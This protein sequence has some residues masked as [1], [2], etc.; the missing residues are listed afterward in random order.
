MGKSL[1][2][3]VIV[4]AI[5]LSGCGRAP[6][7]TPTEHALKN[8]TLLTWQLNDP[9]S[10]APTFSLNEKN[11]TTGV[12]TTG[13]TYPG[14][15]RFEIS[16]DHKKV[17]VTVLGTDFS[18]TIFMYDVAS[19]KMTQIPHNQT[20]SYS[21]GGAVFDA[22]SESFIIQEDE[23]IWN[24]SHAPHALFKKY[25]KAGRLL[26][27]KKIQLEKDMSL[28]AFHMTDDNNLSA[29][30]SQQLGKGEPFYS[31]VAN[32]D[33]EKGTLTRVE[34]TTSAQGYTNYSWLSP[35]GKY[36]VTDTELMSVAC[37]NYERAS[38]LSVTNIETSEEVAPLGLVDPVEPIELLAWSPDETHV[39]L[40][41]S[42]T[43]YCE[44]AETPTFAIIDLQDEKVPAQIIDA[45]GVRELLL[46]NWQAADFSG[47]LEDYIFNT[48]NII[49]IV[50]L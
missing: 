11:L 16:P 9:G 8:P 34:N 21:P 31:Y 15:P 19:R 32:I 5:V 23:E 29:V 36:F 1:K 38:S 45:T 14:T 30:V 47:T 22:Y 18:T 17:L 43:L 44:K 27:E 50:E 6:L 26:W 41:N 37:S 35:S 20:D 3:I 42:P 10:A 25:D 2:T 13:T 40:A 12:S 46:N 33:L 39:L 4:F 24:N 49:G 48:P 28:G 7:P